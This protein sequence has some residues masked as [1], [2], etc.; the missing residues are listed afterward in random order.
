M[1]T[2]LYRGVPHSA[3]IC[4]CYSLWGILAATSAAHREARHEPWSVGWRFKCR[5]VE[6]RWLDRGSEQGDVIHVPISSRPPTGGDVSSDQLGRL[7]TD[8]SLNR[9]HEHLN[10]VSE[11]HNYQL[12]HLGNMPSRGIQTLR[13]YSCHAPQPG[14]VLIPY[15]LQLPRLPPAFVQR[16]PISKTEPLLVLPHINIPCIPTYLGHGHEK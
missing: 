12:K 11:H 1:I 14:Q 15:T 16:M 6:P 5:D 3:R 7:C 9:H 8:L 10:N 2:N 13:Q 4:S